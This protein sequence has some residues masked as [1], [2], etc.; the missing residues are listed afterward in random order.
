MT[1]TRPPTMHQRQELRA[2]RLQSA[3]NNEVKECVVPGCGRRRTE[4]HPYCTRHR[5]KARLFGHPDAKRIN[6]KREAK[7][8]HREVLRLLDLYPKHEGV[9]LA[10]RIL[11]EWMQASADGDKKQP[12]YV[13]AAR[14]FRHGVSPKEVLAGTAAVWLH[15][16]RRGLPDDERLTCRLA[17]AAI[18]LAPF[19]RLRVHYAPITRTPSYSYKKP[20]RMT[21]VETGEFLRQTLH[22]IYLQIEKA[23]D[24]LEKYQQDERKKLSAPFLPL[25]P[26]TPTR[27][28]D[29]Q[30]E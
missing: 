3:A 16:Q 15:C 2:D 25:T 29:T 24:G 6:I 8:E 20:S 14:L 18:H 12:G 4:F 1:Y 10:L 5:A 11:G 23:C 17:T 27:E 9:A 22:A 19:E 13:D 30:H 7:L 26:A 21:I 28:Q